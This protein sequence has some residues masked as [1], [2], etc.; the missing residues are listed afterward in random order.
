MP[1]NDERPPLD[2]RLLAV[3]LGARIGRIRRRIADDRSRRR[4][5]QERGGIVEPVKSPLF[6]GK[7]SRRANAPVDA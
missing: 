5:R 4:V 3:P 6:C 1:A 7:W 2:E